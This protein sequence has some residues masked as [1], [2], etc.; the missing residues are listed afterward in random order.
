[1]KDAIDVPVN[2]ITYDIVLL[3]RHKEIQA[4]E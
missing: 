2:Y 4:I 1:M 3:G